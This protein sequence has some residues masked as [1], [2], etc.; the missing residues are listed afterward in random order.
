[1][2]ERPPEG[3]RVEKEALESEGNF[4]WGTRY[5]LSFAAHRKENG[6][7]GFFSSAE[8]PRSQRECLI[9]TGGRVLRLRPSGKCKCK[10]SDPFEL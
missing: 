2:G 8:E 6:K 4:L 9:Q 3:R 5:S 7:A 10:Y 1:M